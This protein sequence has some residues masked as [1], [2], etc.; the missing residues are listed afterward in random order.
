ML[1]FKSRTK[2]FVKR[3]ARTVC[4][5]L[6]AG[7]V[8]WVSVPYQAG[9]PVSAASTLSELQDR[10]QEL[11]SQKAENDEKLD[12]LKEDTQKQA[13]YKETLNAQIE[14]VQ[15]EIDSYNLEINALNDQITE[16]EAEIRD[17]I[18]DDTKKHAD[19]GNGEK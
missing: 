2:K 13:E 7:A 5:L 8:A 17:I 1:V 18:D 14:T 6:L 9:T 11:E 15:Q 10:Q 16:K 19:S 4:A 12:A 3:A